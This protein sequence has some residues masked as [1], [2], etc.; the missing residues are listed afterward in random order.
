M[1]SDF[2]E[3]TITGPAGGQISMPVGVPV[4]VGSS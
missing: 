1:D 4:Q 3:L 2:F